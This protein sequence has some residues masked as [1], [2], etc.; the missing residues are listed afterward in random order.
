MGESFS[1]F[2]KRGQVHPNTEPQATTPWNEGAVLLL[3]CSWKTGTRWCSSGYSSQLTWSVWAA[4]CSSAS[5]GC[6]LCNQYQKHKLSTTNTWSVPDTV[7][8][9]RNCPDT[10][11]V[12]FAFQSSRGLAA[13]V[14]S[15]P[16]SSH[17][18]N[19][20]PCTLSGHREK[21]ARGRLTRW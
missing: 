8:A 15:S 18:A 5:I 4:L 17:Y 20:H 3:P 21:T 9:L 6:I 12:K 16:H 10:S 2:Y 19:W 7:S 13:P 11:G 14:C 1:Y